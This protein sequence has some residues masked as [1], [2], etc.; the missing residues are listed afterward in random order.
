MVVPDLTA[1]TEYDFSGM[2]YYNFTTNVTGTPIAPLYPQAIL[3]P[4]FAFPAWILCIPS[5]IWHFS[6]GNIAAGSVVTWVVLN[7]FYNAINPLIWPRDNI[8]EWFDGKIWCDI[9]VRIQVGTVVGI[10]ASTTMIIRKLARV[11]DT[12]N[13]VVSSSRNSKL[14]EKIWEVV[15]CWGYPLVMILLYYIVQPIRY[16]IFG[17]VGCVSGYDTSWPSIVISFM[18]GPI[19]MLAATYYA[20]LLIYRL[21]RYR[22]EFSRLISARNTTKSRFVRLFILCMITVVAYTPYTIWLLITLCGAIKDPYDWDSIHGPQ[23]NTIMMIPALGQVSIE[24]WIQVATGYVI[25]FVY[26]TGADAHNLY[27]K[28]LLLV[29]L[30]KWFPSLYN[31]N[32]APSTFIAARSWSSSVSSKAKSMFWS[33]SDS[34]TETMDGTTANGSVRHNSVTPTQVVPTRCNTLTLTSRLISF[35][36][37]ILA[38]QPRRTDVLP[39]YSPDYTGRSLVSISQAQVQPS[40]HHASIGIETHA[41]ATDEPAVPGASGANGVQVSRELRQCCCNKSEVENEGKGGKDWA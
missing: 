29:G 4:L 33:K 7:N 17:I 19:T 26:G 2:S 6:Q 12:S 3:L 22:R 40:V 32:S 39:L 13:I 8:L 35:F 16:F 38:R 14:K 23:F 9:G 1:S 25:F 24:R 10:A 11:M 20:V 18:W 37:S 41:W 5:L 21:Y 27:K 36:T 30:G 15:W 31:L 34:E 28:M